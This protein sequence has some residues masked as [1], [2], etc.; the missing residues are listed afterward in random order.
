MKMRWAS[1]VLSLTASAAP[2]QQPMVGSSQSRPAV[3][4]GVEADTSMNL[5]PDGGSSSSGSAFSGNHNF[6]N[7]IGFVS[8]PLQSI[9]PRA[10]TAIYPLFGSAWV[11]TNPPLPDSNFQ[12]Y[13]P[14]MTVALTERLAI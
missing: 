6:R 4:S 7:F 1:L 10:V 13:G 3:V 5:F 9:D 12:V 11:D 2:A 8:N 14:G